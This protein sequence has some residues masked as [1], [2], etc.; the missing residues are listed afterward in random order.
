MS[1]IDDNDRKKEIQKLKSH[2]RTLNWTTPKLRDELVRLFPSSEDIDTVNNNQHKNAVQ[3]KKNLETFCVPGQFFR[4]PNNSSKPERCYISVLQ[5]N[6]TMPSNELHS[7]IA[8]H[9]PS[10]QSL[11]TKYIYVILEKKSSDT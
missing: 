5:I 8:R 9:V 7:F 3:F 6:P 1:L 11:S 10:H 4:V 2:Y